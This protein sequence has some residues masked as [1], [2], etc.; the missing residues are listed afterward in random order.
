MICPAI[1][2]LF[3]I[4]AIL[5]CTSFCSAQNSAGSEKENEIAVKNS[6]P[7]RILTSGK[8]ITIKSTKNIKSIIVWAASG[9]RIVE[10]KDVNE[11]SYNFR[12]TVNEKVFFV[13]LQLADGKIYS[14]KIGIQ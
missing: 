13:M 4:V 14:E 2:N 9:H 3:T 11:N 10:Q 1:R 12:I 6:N 7:F 8:Q 5:L